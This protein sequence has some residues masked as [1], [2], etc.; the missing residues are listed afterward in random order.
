MRNT[1]FRKWKWKRESDDYDR[2]GSRRRETLA[3]VAA[4][5]AAAAANWPAIV[6]F[7]SSSRFF[8]YPTLL[9]SFYFYFFILNFLEFWG[10]LISETLPCLWKDLEFR[11]HLP[12]AVSYLK[13]ISFYLKHFLFSFIPNISS[14]VIN[15]FQN[16]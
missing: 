3:V 10:V 14:I 15:I 6:F 12:E 2:E 8:R 9:F 16:H 13:Q 5:A 1:N 7:L 11:G 4:A